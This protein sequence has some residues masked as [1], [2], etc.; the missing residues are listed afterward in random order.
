M[1]QFVNSS[2]FAYFSLAMYVA[3]LTSGI[4]LLV[5]READNL[6]FISFVNIVASLVG[7]VGFA[8]HS[9]FVFHLGWTLMGLGGIANLILVGA[10]KPSSVSA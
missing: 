4:S 7:F 5:R 10:S 2:A 9:S 1:M 6:A 3:V 8:A